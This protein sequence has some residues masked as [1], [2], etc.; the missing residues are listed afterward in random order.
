LYIDA[1][2][3]LRSQDGYDQ[4]VGPGFWERGASLS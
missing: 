2:G 1:D 3:Y 4:P